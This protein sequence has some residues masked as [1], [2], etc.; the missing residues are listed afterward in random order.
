[1]PSEVHPFRELEVGVGGTHGKR[2]VCFDGREPQSIK[3][4]QIISFS[5]LCKFLIK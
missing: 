1:M 4:F 2:C 3:L 5:L